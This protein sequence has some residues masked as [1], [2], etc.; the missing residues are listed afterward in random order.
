MI[1]IQQRRYLGSKTKL[2]RFID[3]TLKKEG[4]R[5]KSFA[6]IFAG[7]GVVANHYSETCKIILND[8]LE[9]N[10]LVYIAFFDEEKIRHPWLKCKINSYNKLSP[11]QLRDNYFSINFSDTYFSHDNSKIIGCIRED[12]ER[13]FKL[14]NCNV[15][16]RAYLITTLIYALDRIASTVGHYDAFLDSKNRERQELQLK[17]LKLK[18]PIDRV[19]IYNKDANDLVSKIEPDVVYIDPPYN[20]RQYSDTYH[21]LENIAEWRKQP[22]SGI[23]RKIDR[24]HIKSSYNLKVATYAFRELISNIKARYI[25]VSY[26]DMGTSG[27]A[28]SQ[29]KIND[30]ELQL[31]LEKRGRV[32]VYE[33]PINQFTT[34][35]STNTNLKERLFLCHIETG[36]SKS[37]RTIKANSK[38]QLAKHVKSPL[39]YTGGKYRLLPQLEK[40]FPMNI[41][42]FYDVFCGGANVGIN[43]KAKRT[44]CIDNNRKVIEMLDCL[45]NNAFE[46]ITRKI[47]DT[48]Q[49][50]RLSESYLKGYD[51][52]SVNSSQGLGRYN[53][54]QYLALRDFYNRS[55]IKDPL[56][57]L[58]LIIFSFNNQ[59]RFNAKGEYN[60]PVGKRD[61]NGNSRKNIFQF[62]TQ[63]N[64]KII[65]FRVD[66]FRKLVKYKLNKADFIYL[67]PPYLLGLAT[68]NE[69][70]SW[71]IQDELDLYKVLAEIDTQGIKFALSNVVQHKGQHNTVLVNWSEEH[72]FKIN[73]IRQNYG[74]SNY[75]SRAGMNKTQEVLITN[76]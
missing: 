50:F 3:K 27:N 38:I 10:Y 76:Y 9:S 5:P 75:Q 41:N 51:Y 73:K 49:S 43:A 60:L 66:D 14:G 53:K 16:E 46:D 48:I 20:S 7:T 68:Y 2:L 29:A 67:D 71:T 15:R 17:E 21:L 28:R 35:R 30:Y 74:N 52:Y 62:N 37:P 59:I 1:H 8:I 56:V 64:S 26:N 18:K 19:E 54:R 42:T 65:S 23:A 57:L 25:L 47:L 34:G 4:I 44:M 36:K 33:M 45:K 70:N 58:S 6:D 61:Y 63:A 12:I 39:N 72:K 69:A 24:S 22:V 31:A 11:K 32:K 40:Y 55:K 13:E